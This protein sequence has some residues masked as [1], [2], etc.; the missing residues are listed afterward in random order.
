MKKRV[1]YSLY[2]VTD[3][4]LMTTASVEDS[5]EKA[6]AGGC[7][8]VQLREKKVSSG[9]FYNTALKVRNVTSRYKVPLII[10]DRADIAKAVDAEGVH[11]GQDDLP[12]SAARSVVGKSKIVGVSVRSLA[13]A[14]EASLCGAN[15]IGVGAMFA[16]S[17]KIDADFVS[18][19]ELQ[20]IRKSV[21][22]PIVV[23]G[24]IYKENVPLFFGKGIDG[25]AVVSAVV[26]Q[27][28]IT[29]AARELKEMIGAGEKLKSQ[30]SALFQ[31]FLNENQAAK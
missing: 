6:I 5:V 7:T 29:H 22:I 24:G 17:T 4:E 23:I 21:N 10:N 27:N 8:V 28:N 16:T 20:K 2:L 18:M 13:E 12:Y 11:V 26:A 25:I 14:L 19:E 15:Y 1:D 9:E 3:R 31:N 30:T